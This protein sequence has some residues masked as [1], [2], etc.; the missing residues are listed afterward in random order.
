MSYTRLTTTELDFLQIKENLKTYFKRAN[1]PFKDWD[2]DGS[3]LN[4]LLDALAYNTHYNAMLA[5]SA[6]NESF[7]DSAQIRSNVV[8]RARILGYTPRSVISPRATVELIID[9]T[10]TSISRI[11]LPRGTTFTTTF[12]DKKYNYVLLNAV[13]AS[14]ETSGINAGRYVFSVD[15]KNELYLAEGE[16]KTVTYTVDNNIPRQRF[17]IP[18]SDTD[19]STLQ[20]TVR[21][22][23]S[24]TSVNQYSNFTDLASVTSESTIYFLNENGEGKYEIYF[25]DGIFGN[26]LGNLNVVELEYIIT[27]GAESNRADT[28]SLVSS[29]DYTLGGSETVTTVTSASGG[30][31]KESIDS[32][33]SNAPRSLIAQNRAVTVEDYITVVKGVIP[34]IETIT[35]WGGDQE[36]FPLETNTAGEEIHAGKVYISAK[37]YTDLVLSPTQK[38]AVLEILDKKRVITVKPVFVDPD[39]VYLT[40]NVYFGYDNRATALQYNEL[41]S[42]VFDGIVAYTDANLEKFTGVFR[43][44]NLLSSVD[45][46]DPAIINSSVIVNLYKFTPI[47]R[48]N[49]KDELRMDFSTPLYGDYSYTLPSESTIYSELSTVLDLSAGVTPYKLVAVR[50]AITGGDYY[51][52][53]LYDASGTKTR[54]TTISTAGGTVTIH[55]VSDP[56]WPLGY[57]S[58]STGILLISAEAAI[59]AVLAVEGLSSLTGPQTTRISTYAAQ[60]VES[61][62][63]SS[64][65]DSPVSLRVWGRPA[66]DMIA[67]RRNILLSND[68]SR[69]V[70]TG[71]IDTVVTSGSS[72][73]VRYV[74]APRD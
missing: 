45:S 57:V 6:I 67:P 20:V 36:E 40:L 37:P 28:F 73:A 53:Y 64:P 4:V 50:T 42:K 35:V 21:E 46:L 44:S 51:P 59:A 3:G 27:S 17:A 7:I 62:I 58:L 8:S 22:N 1:S 11:S 10:D 47:A 66:G 52:V 61:I 43:H 26:K 13:S 55:Q 54:F 74:T 68:T 69:M 48:R 32:I 29:I 24:S 9:S 49:D 56:T 15:T 60:M 14:L 65:G 39:Y 31:D 38:S 16:L 33:R 5:H 30:S 18:D 23:A 41:R 34:S 12:A 19:T 2:F 70:V 25:G 71:A 72:G 63:P